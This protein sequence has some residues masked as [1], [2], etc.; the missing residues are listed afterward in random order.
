MAK[1]ESKT[2]G[3][4]EP[5]GTIADTAQNAIT[6]IASVMSLLQ[7]GV[8]TAKQIL[9][10]IPSKAAF[11]KAIA[12]E[13]TNLCNDFKEVGAFYIVVDPL[14]ETYGGRP[15]PAY[16]LEIAKDE[17]GLHLFR[18]STVVNPE[19]PDDGATFFVNSE[20]AKSLN[21]ADLG[22]YW[23]D[24]KGRKQGD[25]GFKP[26]T[27]KIAG[28]KN[29]QFV[30]GGY[31]PATW[32]GTA[33]NI[34]QLDNGFIPPQMTPKEVLQLMSDAFD[35]EGDVAAFEVI[36]KFRTASFTKVPANASD[37]GP[38]TESGAA[39]TSFDPLT[40]QNQDLFLNSNTALSLTERTKITTKVRSGRPNFAG[41][42]QLDGI[43]LACLV[44]VFGVADFKALINIVD[45]IKNFFPDLPELENLT[46]AANALID[47]PT[48]KLTV[49]TNGKYGALIV[50]DFIRGERSKA[51]G[52]ITKITDIGASVRTRKEYVPVFDQDGELLSVREEEKDGNP[53]GVWRDVDIEYTVVAGA[54]RTFYPSEN[55]Y[56]ATQV[57]TDNPSGG[58]K[59]F[60]YPIKGTNVFTSEDIA[61]DS[62]SDA[63]LPKYGFVKGIDTSVPESV[64]PDFK[65]FK[66]KDQIPGYADFF[67]NIIELANSLNGFAND[68][69]K[70]ISELLETIDDYLA[71]FQEVADN[72]TKFLEI[73]TKGIPS[74]GIYWLPIKTTGGTAAIQSAITSSEGQPP[75]DLKYTGG[76]MIISVSGVG[77]ASITPLFESLGLK[78]QSV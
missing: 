59:Q 31:N 54:L 16:G 8:G 7:Q 21:L 68:T 64:L 60:S 30:P 15:Q 39:V 49:T 24:R 13:I 18:S 45:S 75:E 5:I 65:S 58:G 42:T 43:E 78:S 12:N 70:F 73:F 27:P 4:G 28:G 77:G 11:I 66:I 35:D 50:G 48:L 56:E 23:R 19:S 14:N 76:I 1:W 25:T 10:L 2:L 9:E 47:P 33:D 17:N 69:T 3:L 55:V 6:S 61:P 22:Q 38:Y 44:G 32:T 26:P 74:S 41:N 72:I 71:Y 36:K 46:R 37:V 63:D 20:Y 67:D 29:P 51:V 53:D 62:I 34:V 52:K 40:L 57:S